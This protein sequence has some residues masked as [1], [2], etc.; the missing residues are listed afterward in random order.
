MLPEG[1][2][3]A[4]SITAVSLCGQ[5]SEPL[6]LILTNITMDLLVSN[7]ATSDIN[8]QQ[9]QVVAVG[10]GL[11]VTLGVVTIVMVASIITVTVIILAFC[12][13]SHRKG[14]T[15]LHTVRYSDLAQ[16]TQN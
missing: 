4:A 12:V 15:F 2:Y 6:E 7:V 8:T 11:G 1:N 9:N 10:A 13:H 5:R 3:T 16:K 14:A